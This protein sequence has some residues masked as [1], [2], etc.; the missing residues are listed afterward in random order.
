MVEYCAERQH[1][2]PQTQPRGKGGAP[3]TV[4]HVCSPAPRRLTPPNQS[5]G[6]RHIPNATP[7][8]RAH[9]AHLRVPQRVELPVAHLAL[10]QEGLP[11]VGQV[12]GDDGILILPHGLVGIRQD[13]HEE[14]PL[15]VLHLLLGLLHHVLGVHARLGSAAARRMGRPPAREW[16]I[17]NAAAAWA[18][19]GTRRTSLLMST[20][21]TS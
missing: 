18:N 3:P 12:S 1:E 4:P 9:T 15:Q 8:T 5:T 2:Q 13:H 20:L 14:V 17:R 6:R 11:R 19:F 21:F 10:A 16:C 7:D